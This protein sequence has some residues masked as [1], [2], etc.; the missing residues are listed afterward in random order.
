MK[1]TAPILEKQ[2]F[3]LDTCR[4]QAELSL[5]VFK[6][7]T[8]LYQQNTKISG[9]NLLLLL[10]AVETAFTV[11][12]GRSGEDNKKFKLGNVEQTLQGFAGADY[13]LQVWLDACCYQDLKSGAAKL[14]NHAIWKLKMNFIHSSLY[15]MQ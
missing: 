8:I 1:Y 15:R 11:T 12:F 3:R 4:P 6:I 2:G 7:H 10:C 14:L 5:R 9:D 13:Q